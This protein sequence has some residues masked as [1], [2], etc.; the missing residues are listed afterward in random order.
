MADASSLDKFVIPGV[1]VQN[2][3]ILI[4]RGSGEIVE[5]EDKKTKER[6]LRLI[7]PVELPNGSIKTVTVNKGSRKRLMEHF[8][9]ETEDWVDKKVIVSLSMVEIFGSLKQ[10]MYLNPAK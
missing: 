7:L 6:V 9:P 8:G 2:G 3:D 10:V 5:Y 1:N 4:I